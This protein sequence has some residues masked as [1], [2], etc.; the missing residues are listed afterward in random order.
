VFDEASSLVRKTTLHDVSKPTTS[1]EEQVGLYIALNRIISCCFK[2]FPIWFFFLA[3]ESLVGELVPPS[4]AGRSGDYTRD[5]SSRWVKSDEP[6]LKRFPPFLA[7]QLDV[8]DRWRM[9]DPAKRKDELRKPM[10][11]FTTPKEM[12]IFG[13]PLWYAYTDKPQEMYKVAKLKLIG[14]QQNGGYDPK[15]ENHVFAVLS[16]RLSLDVCLQNP[17]AISFA[18]AAVNFYM[19]VAVSIDQETGLLDTV[20]PSEPVLAKAAMEHLCQGVNW[21]QSIETLTLKLLE[22][23]LV[24]KGV[25]G[26]LYARLVLILAHD[27]VRLARGLRTSDPTSG[28]SSDVP[29]LMPTFTVSDLLKAL[30]ADNHHTSIDAL[31][32]DIRGARM[33]FTHFVP[34]YETLTPEIVPEL[35][36]DLLRRC[37]AMQLEFKQPTYDLFL[38][39]Y[40]GDV[41]REFEVSECGFVVVQ[42]KNRKK[43]T[44]LED[45]FKENFT[46]IHPEG[47]DREE[48]KAAASIRNKDTF[49]F[50]GATKPILF[51]LFDFGVTRSKH[52]LSPLVQVSRSNVETAPELWAIHSQGY[53]TEVFGCLKNMDQTNAYRRFFASV[54][55]GE[56][57]ADQLCMR[58]KIF[59]KLGRE[60]RYPERKGEVVEPVEAESSAKG[61]KGKGKMEVVEPV[62]AES[63]AK[64]GKGKG[65]FRNLLHLTKKS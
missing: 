21:T 42:V 54:P 52:A 44:T 6:R 11:N 58:N 7:L 22:G 62:E 64:G 20:T 45:I 18:S 27:W 49:V 53:D 12:A 5:S 25:K 63:S 65:K 41:D 50:N 28:L 34:G 36:Q 35:C 15:N 56:T 43:A 38:P 51:L 57:E 24:E 23:G 3:T 37:A 47:R 46:K 1:D 13:R 2:E 10:A 60:F 55:S 48:R 8:E 9:Q 26:E 59:N 40:F 4:N 14:G 19:R 32:K 17:E 29:E 61:G 33:N 30:Y 16:F 31:P 39:V